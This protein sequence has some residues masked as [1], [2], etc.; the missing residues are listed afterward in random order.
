MSLVRQSMLLVAAASISCSMGV[1]QWA[2]EE[3]WGGEIG[4][5]SKSGKGAGICQFDRLRSCSFRVSSLSGTGDEKASDEREQERSMLKL[6]SCFWASPTLS[7]PSVVARA[8]WFLILSAKEVIKD[9]L[10][11]GRRDARGERQLVQGKKNEEE[12]KRIER[13]S[14]RS[15]G[16]P[17]RKWNEAAWKALVWMKMKCDEGD[18]ENN[19]QKMTQSS[20]NHI[21]LNSATA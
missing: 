20:A 7:P 21:G 4:W 16:E 15:W 17:M 13:S 3:Y 5:Y 8:A 6:L 14:D 18:A 12:V 9:I 2:L 1:S 11:D 19:R 10:E